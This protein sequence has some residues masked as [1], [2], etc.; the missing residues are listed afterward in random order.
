MA[1]A[2]MKRTK[3]RW[4]QGAIKNPGAFTRYCKSKGFKGV[5]DKCIQ[6]ALAAGGTVAKR[7]RL[8][9]TL[10]KIRGKKGQ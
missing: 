8:A 9:R 6:E 2:K 5:T 3:N 7:A 4:I 1:V 10:R